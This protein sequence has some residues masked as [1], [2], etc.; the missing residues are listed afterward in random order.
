MMSAYK[1]YNSL[2][3]ENAKTNLAIMLETAVYDLR[4][5]AEVF[6]RMFLL[7][8]VADAFGK[9]FSGYIVGMS[10]AELAFEVIERTGRRPQRFTQYARPARSREYWAGMVLA[11]YQWHTAMTFM[12][13]DD[14]V[15]LS[16]VIQM[17]TPYHEMDIMHFIEEMNRRIRA[18]KDSTRLA[19][20]RTAAGL[21]QRHLSELS[22]VPL[23]TIQQYEQ[24]IKN[25]N[26]AQFNTLRALSR[27]LFCNVDALAEP[28]L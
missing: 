26:H 7:S 22:G 6:Y 10:G 14:V 18:R 4:I 17:Y 5:D 3:L 1:A 24:R 2:F 8:G 20:L 9:G 25:I 19:I 15:P 21:S 27:A 16:E 11:H 23:R 13:I 28:E 12:D